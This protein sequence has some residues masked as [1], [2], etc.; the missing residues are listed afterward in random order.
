MAKL[1]IVVDMQNDFVRGHLSTPEARETI[2]GIQAKIR[3]YLEDGHGVLFTMD[4]H[5]DSD[6]QQQDATAEAAALPKHC[7]KG[8][9]GWE[10]VDELKPY[11]N[12]DNVI[13][14]P[15]FMAAD[16]EERIWEHVA[17]TAGDEIELCGVCTDICVISNALYLRAKFP[18]AKITVD[19]ACCAG[20]TPDTHQAALTAMK[21][22]LID[23]GC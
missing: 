12:A 9:G 16:E 11:V 18:R 3:R 4:T 6:Y 7:I 23:V 19:P 13:E 15:T 20:V 22:C 10:I 17:D 21:N 2:G 8:T 5:L 1:L 14:K